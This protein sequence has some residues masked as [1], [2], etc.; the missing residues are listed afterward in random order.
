MYRIRI[1]ALFVVLVLLVQTSI[2]APRR[3]N[4]GPK[5]E[6]AA[7]EKKKDKDP[8]TVRQ[9]IERV[10]N[11]ADIARGFWGVEAV[12]LSTGKTLFTYNGDKLFTPASNTKLFTTAAALADIPGEGGTHGRIL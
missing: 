8:K 12:S 4:S 10:L 2:A 3:A 1:S 5:N 9:R 11:Q 6:K 7:A